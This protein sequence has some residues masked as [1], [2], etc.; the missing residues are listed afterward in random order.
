[1]SAQ[2][3]GRYTHA[4]VETTEI[5]DAYVEMLKLS[6]LDLLGPTTTRFVVVKSEFER[7]LQPGID[8]IPGGTTTY[9]RV[10]K[11]VRR[12]FPKGVPKITGFGRIQ[13]VPEENRTSRL[14]GHDYP[15]N[16]LTMM[17]YER[18][19]NVQRC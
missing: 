6:L 9:E 15:A 1:H 19:S 13:T 17:G 7:K 2:P 18:L 12:A 4:A 3:T 16:A 14:S 5:Y 8:R 11:G 10:L